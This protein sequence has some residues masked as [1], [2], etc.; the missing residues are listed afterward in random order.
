MG[1]GFPIVTSS[2][3]VPPDRML[4]G[5][6]CLAMVGGSGCTV[7]LATLE[8]AP[9]A[10]SALE[11]PL[12]WLGWVPMTLP[13]TTTVTVQEPLA[14]IV[15]LDTARAVCPAVK[16]LPAAP[17]QVPPA[18]PAALTCMLASVSVKAAAV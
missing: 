2:V 3:V 15:R 6:N 18:A 4:V 13:S 17:A 7:R 11:T 1:F 16:P 9:V 5:V 8:A 12:A 14:G 10:A